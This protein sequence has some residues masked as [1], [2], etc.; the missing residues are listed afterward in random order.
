M[1]ARTQLLV[2][3]FLF[4]IAAVLFIVWLAGFDFSHR[5]PAA[6]LAAIFALMGGFVSAFVAD[7]Y[8]LMP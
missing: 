4:G 5:G 2:V 6:A 8:R 1:S 7:I 3:A